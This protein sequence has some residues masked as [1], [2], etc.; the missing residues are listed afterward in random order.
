M[1]L[2]RKGHEHED[3]PHHFRERQTRENSEKTQPGGKQSNHQEN[4]N[5]NRLS[6][7]VQQPLAG[8]SVKNKRESRE[9]PEEGGE[10]Y[11]PK[12]DSKVRTSLSGPDVNH[13]RAEHGNETI[14]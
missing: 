14:W 12:G 13:H 10:T 4:Q 11:H 7:I 3:H 2:F 5:S 1:K 8:N 9:R 6:D